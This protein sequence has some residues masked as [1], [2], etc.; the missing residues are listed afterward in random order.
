MSMNKVQVQI[1][2]SL[3]KI[4]KCY[5]TEA[6]CEAALQHVG[7]PDGF[8]FPRGQT[9]AATQFVRCAHRYGQRVACRRQTSLRSGT[10]MEQSKPPL[11]TWPVAMYLIGE[12]KTNLSALELMRHLGVSCPAAWP[13]KHKLMQAMVERESGCQLGGVVQL[14]Y[15]C[16][17]GERDSGNAGR[18]SEDKSPFVISI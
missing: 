18:G 15:A 5:G 6:Q 7:W 9:T 13:M 2:L 14:D 1:E 3:P 10:L 11:R 16:L 8:V 17:G 12:R 4:L